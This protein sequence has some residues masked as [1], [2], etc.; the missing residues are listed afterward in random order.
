[1]AGAVKYLSLVTVVLLTACS[2]RPLL[3]TDTSLLPKDSSETSGLVCTAT[4]FISIND[5]GHAAELQQ[6]DATLKLSRIPLPLS[7][8]DWEALTSDARHLYIGDTGNNS[9]S[10]QHGEIHRLLHNRINGAVRVDGTLLYRF[11]DYP[12]SPPQPYQHDFDVEAL[13]YADGSLWM[14]SKSWRS[15]I[16]R[17]YQ[18]DPHAQTMQT[19]HAKALIPDL[20]GLVTDAVYLPESQLFL[21]TG[22]QNYQHQLLRFA[23]Q[24]QFDAFVA[25]TDRQFK[26]LKVVPLPQAGQ[27]EG[28]CARGDE[29]WLSQEQYQ[30]SPARLWREPLVETALKQ[31][32]AVR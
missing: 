18:L 11:H 10:R 17:V 4:G 6:L 28:I 19:L 14:F 21:L 2:S 32:S 15:G 25:V 12:L 20:P 23:L 3:L 8:L 7:Q 9:G 29:I 24:G 5:S 27:L 13:A 31:L 30:H 16:S 22:Y 1:M 26:L